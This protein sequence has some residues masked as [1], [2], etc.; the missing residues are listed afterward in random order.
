VLQTRVNNFNLLLL[1]LLLLQHAQQ[2][3]KRYQTSPTEDSHQQTVPINICQKIYC[4]RSLSSS[5]AQLLM[6]MCTL[7]LCEP[8]MRSSKRANT[9]KPRTCRP[10][11]VRPSAVMISQLPRETLFAKQ[12]IHLLQPATKRHHIINI[13]L[14]PCPTLYTKIPAHQQC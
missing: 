4:M 9:S 5:V 12:C 10:G 1:L 7:T 3:T 14:S 2:V 6:L 11:R 8:E 13:I